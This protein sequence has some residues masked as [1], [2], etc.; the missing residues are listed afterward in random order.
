MKNDGFSNQIMNAQARFCPQMNIL[1]HTPSGT[2]NAEYQNYMAQSKNAAKINFYQNFAQSPLSQKA[3][4]AD[5]LK[6]KQVKRDLE[7]H[8]LSFLIQNM[9]KPRLPS[10]IAVNFNRQTNGP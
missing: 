9:S 6:N 5:Q 7:T 1:L 2:Y 4:A 10:G 3:A 8:E